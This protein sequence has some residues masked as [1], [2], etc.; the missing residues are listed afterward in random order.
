MLAGMSPRPTAARRVLAT[1]PFDRS[2]AVS[3][4]FELDDWVSHDRYGL[5]KVVGGEPGVDV[6]ADFRG[7]GILRVALPSSKLSKL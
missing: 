7:G 2:P 5:G 3:E 1:S 6:V 4:T